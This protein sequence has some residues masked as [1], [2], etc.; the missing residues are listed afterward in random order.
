VIHEHHT[1]Y[2]ERDNSGDMLSGI[3]VG[4]EIANNNRDSYREPEYQAPT[5]Y[6]EPSRSSD[7]DRSSGNVSFSS[8]DSDDDSKGDSGPVAFSDDDT[9]STSDGGDSGDVSF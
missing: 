7:D 3:L 6:E 8:N 9:P 5:R 4:E 1:T 2:V